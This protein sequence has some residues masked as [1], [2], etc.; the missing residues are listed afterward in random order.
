MAS[1]WLSLSECLSFPGFMP[2][3][4]LTVYPPDKEAGSPAQNELTDSLERVP[5]V[6]HTSEIMVCSLCHDL[7]KILHSIQHY[8]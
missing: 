3:E 8:G 5:P 1:V 7:K 4:E 2:P 6:Y